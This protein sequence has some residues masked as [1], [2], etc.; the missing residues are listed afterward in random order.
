M[1]PAGALREL[2]V[3]E[4][5]L[6]RLN[7]QLNEMPEKRAILQIRAKVAEIRALGKR[8][9]AVVHSLDAAV[10]RYEDETQVVA[11]KIDEEQ[12]KL[13][14]GQIKNPKELQAISVELGSLKRRMDQLET[15]MLAQMQ[16]SESATGQVDKVAAAI[17]AWEEKEAALTRQFKVRGSD[18]LGRIEA[19]TK[20]RRALLA[21][22]P[23]DLRARYEALLLSRH[24]I[25]VGILQDGMCSACR[26]GLPA[27]KIDTLEHGPD[28][29]TCPDCGR[30]LIVRWAE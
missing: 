12:A 7:K 1:D 16:K 19:D 18:L 26:V 8:T 24:G 6:A 30:I 11:D 23:D 10:K 15:E 5:D 25:A 2:Q 14:S 27:G 28:I 29:S 22:L 4:L 3:R 13:L 21:A 20:A 9:E 17:L